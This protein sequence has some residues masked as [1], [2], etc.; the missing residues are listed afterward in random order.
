MLKAAADG[1]KTPA[2]IEQLFS[3]TEKEARWKFEKKYARVAVLDLLKQLIVTGNSCLYFPPDEERVQNYALD[4]YVLSKDTSGELLEVITVDKKSL[5]ALEDTLRTEVMRS[6]DDISPDEDLTARIVSIYTF[7]RRNPEKKSEFLVDQSVEGVPIG[8]Q[9]KFPEHLLPW[10]PCHWNR[11]RQEAYGRGLIEDH[12]G[13]FFAMSILVEALVTAGAIATDFKFL[14]KPGSM[15]DVVE[16]NNS[17][18]GTYHYG[19]PDDV[20]PIET[21]KRNELQFV[22]SLVEMYRKQLGKIFLVLSSQIRDSERTTAEENRLRAQELN[23]THGGVFGNLG[24]TLQSPVAELLLRDLDVI[25]KGTNLRPVI[26]TGLDAM[27][28]ASENEK[29]LYY[30]NDLAALNNVPEEIRAAFKTT[31]LMTTLGNGRDIDTSIVMTKEEL[32]QK[33]AAEQEAAMKMQAAQTMTEKSEP[34][35]IA[36]GLTE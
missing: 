2:E 19:N 27:G 30:F 21:G 8:V 18:S 17:A 12:Y 16:M 35:Q 1:N 20:S 4:Q 32:E 33:Q 10:I 6:L 11:V 28:R 3:L 25:V 36:Q 9:E 7:V 34:E 31:D 24:L 13:A 26:M 5:M 15:L 23:K 14:V 29:I 22:L